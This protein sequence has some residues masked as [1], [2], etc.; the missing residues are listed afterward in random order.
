M[1][2]LCLAYGSEEDWKVLTRSEQD[3]LLAQDE[4]LRKRGDVVA[5]VES[6]TT[7]RS[8]N[9]KLTVAKGPFSDFKLPLAGFSLITARDLSEAIE[10]VRD[11]PCARA[12]GAVE[13]WPVAGPG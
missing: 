13:I 10:L 11:T 8:P 6:P 4:V 3:A 7:V 1:R 12:G 9:G 5:A 2:F